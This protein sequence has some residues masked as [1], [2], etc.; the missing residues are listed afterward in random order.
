MRCTN[1]VWP[2]K[3]EDE[4]QKL[5]EECTNLTPE[6]VMEDEDKFAQIVDEYV[7]KHASKELREWLEKLEELEKQPA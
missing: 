3:I 6:S 1:V 4:W 5:F 7:A 2:A